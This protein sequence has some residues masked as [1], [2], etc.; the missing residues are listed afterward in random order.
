MALVNYKRF[1]KTG[2]EWE[3]PLVHN[4]AGGETSVTLSTEPERL[5][6]YLT[7]HPE[8]YMHCNI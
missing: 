1:K 4:M 7:L 6:Y 3:R 2:N 5:I 8:I